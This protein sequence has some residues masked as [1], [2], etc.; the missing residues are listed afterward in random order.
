MAK[1]WE[2]YGP[3]YSEDFGWSWSARSPGGAWMGATRLDSEEACLRAI[4][5]A[6]GEK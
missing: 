3:S 4:R 1:E 6:K 2:V 5:K